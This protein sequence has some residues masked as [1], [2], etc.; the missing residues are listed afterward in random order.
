MIVDGNGNYN[1]VENLDLR[2]S[3]SYHLGVRSFGTAFIIQDCDVTGD[4]NYSS[5]TQS[6]GINLWTSGAIARRCTVKYWTLGIAGYGPNDNYSGTPTVFTVEDNVISDFRP[7]VSAYSDV[8]SIGIRFPLQDGTNLTGTI[9]RGNDV[10]GFACCG[11]STR[12]KGIVIEHNT[13][14]DNEAGSTLGFFYPIHIGGGEPISNH[15]RNTICR[16]NN[17][18]NMTN[19]MNDA[20]AIV[21]GSDSCRVYGNL[22][23]DIDIGGINVALESGLSSSQKLGTKIW[24]NTIINTVRVNNSTYGAIGIYSG[25][26]YDIDISNNISQGIFR[27]LYFEGG[28]GNITTRNNYFIGTNHVINRVL[29]LINWVIFPAAIL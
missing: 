28:L 4:P 29:L 19:S 16:Y 1:T 26:G 3:I 22:I 18:Y 20:Y 9:V 14:H 2:C 12:S 27:N 5:T 17:I 8:F 13:F 23:H 21:V 25:S 15:A 6:G 10:S 24:N 7:R 11:L